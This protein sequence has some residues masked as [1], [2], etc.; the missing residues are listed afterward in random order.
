MM[1]EERVREL[2]HERELEQRGMTNTRT[3]FVKGEN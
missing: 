1:E 2:G 3:L